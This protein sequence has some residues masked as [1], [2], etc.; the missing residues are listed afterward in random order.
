MQSIKIESIAQIHDMLGMPPPAHPLISLVENTA[1]APMQPQVPVMNIRIVAELYTIS[2]KQGNECLVRYGRQSYDF[3]GASLMF[4]APGQA[5][6]PMTE[7]GDLDPSDD[8]WVLVFHPELIRKFPLAG[9]INEYS[10]F[11]YD[12]HEAL[13]VSEKEKDTVSG[14]AR[15]I[16]EEYSQNIDTHSSELIVSN[17]ELMLGYCR[18]FYGRQ[19]MTRSSANRDVVVRLEGFLKEYFDS[20]R[21]EADGVPSVQQCAKEMGYSANYLSDLL[22][23]ETGKTTREHIHYTVVEK[24]KTLLL[25]TE[26][27]V[28]EIAYALGFE[29]PQHFSKLFKNVTGIAPGEY[30]D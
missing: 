18:R 13:H 9:R 2:L 26:E 10:F 29:Y 21:A 15:Q 19:F 11:G 3:Q 24:A 28:S 14:I 12:S 22:K 7:P 25:G 4:V 8:A 27:T 1:Q 30:R 17:L 16:R 23:Q 5:I 20:G 6:T